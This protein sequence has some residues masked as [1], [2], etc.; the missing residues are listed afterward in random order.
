MQKLFFSFGLLLLFA[1][2]SFAQEEE[3]MPEF[4]L[5]QYYFVM[6]T[7]G[8]NSEKIDS[9]KSSK[10]IIGHLKNIK[11][12][13]SEGKLAIVG[14]FGDNGKW[15]GIFIFDVPKKEDAEEILKSDPAIHAGLFNYE[16]HPW[17]S[18]KG[19]CLK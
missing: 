14:P 15:R 10:L 17:W 13:Q 8:E 5:K 11:K 12:L 18:E 16:I 7:V 6:L 1:F 9:A 4:N 3:K 2:S 19:Q